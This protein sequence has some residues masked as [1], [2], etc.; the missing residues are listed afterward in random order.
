MEKKEY[1]APETLVIG[2][3]ENVTLLASTTQE[4]YDESQGGAG[5]LGRRGGWFDEDDE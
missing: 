5:Q 2:M 1:V 4:I 3:E